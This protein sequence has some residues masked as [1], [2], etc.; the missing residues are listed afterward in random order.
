MHLCHLCLVR[1]ASAQVGTGLTCALQPWFAQS[2]RESG[3]DGGRCSLLGYRSE[4][5]QIAQRRKAGPW[6]QGVQ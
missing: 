4:E 5:E 2:S 1:S 6:C 3:E